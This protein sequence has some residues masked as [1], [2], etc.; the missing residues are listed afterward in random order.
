MCVNL[1]DVLLVSGVQFLLVMPHW[2]WLAA[3]LAGCEQAAQGQQQEQQAKDE[4]A[5][6]ATHERHFSLDAWMRR[7]SVWA[8]E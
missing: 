7:P 8:Q 1:A 5:T 4:E 3:R 6:R 2:L